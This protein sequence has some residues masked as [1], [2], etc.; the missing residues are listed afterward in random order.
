MYYLISKEVSKT[1]DTTYHH[2]ILNPGF[3]ANANE[4]ELPR[5][6]RD[7]R[8]KMLLLE[9]SSKHAPNSLQMPFPVALLHISSKHR[10]D[11]LMCDEHAVPFPETICWP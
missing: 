4:I 5:L 10:I 9:E 6:G 7:Y 1:K 11:D 8:G 2:K 3:A